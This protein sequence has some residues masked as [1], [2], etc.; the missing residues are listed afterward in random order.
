MV[1]LDPPAPRGDGIWLAKDREKIE[2][3][4]AISRIF[5][6]TQNVFQSDDCLGL[7]QTVFA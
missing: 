7:Q 3:V 5:D 6:D 4:V 2:R 1:S